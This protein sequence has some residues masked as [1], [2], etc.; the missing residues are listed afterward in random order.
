MLPPENPNS[1]SNKATKRVAELFGII[2]GLAGIE[3]GV[4]ELLQGDVP[5]DGIMI[6][7]I[8]DAYKFWPEASERALTIAPTFLLTGILALTLGILVTLWAG[9]FIERRYG[10]TILLILTLSLFLVGGGFAPIFLS[11][12]AVLMATRIDK[13]LTW[14]RTHLS[15]GVLALLAKLWPWISFLFVV[16]FW[17]TV[18]VQIFGLPLDVAAISGIVSI[19]SIVMVTLMPVAVIVGLSA[20]VHSRN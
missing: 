8:G 11:I 7:A 3:H 15:T 17:S 4:L 20:D 19:L 16:V 1:I 2:V 12:L 6:N 14:W 5:I 10:A 9:I 13:P 18:G